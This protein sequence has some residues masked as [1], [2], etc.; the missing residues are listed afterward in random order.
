VTH[1]NE[2]STCSAA[3]R[4]GEA[5]RAFARPG[6][7]FCQVHDPERADNFKAACAK[8]GQMTAIQGRRRKLDTPAELVKFTSNVI[9]DVFEGQ[10]DPGI[11]RTLFYGVMVQ[12]KLL[13]TAEM[14]DQLEALVQQV[15]LKRG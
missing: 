2:Q 14:A 11:A 5:C 7:P 6:R 15:G 12:G 3:S 4:S 8:G 13:E 1:G 10:I 9:L